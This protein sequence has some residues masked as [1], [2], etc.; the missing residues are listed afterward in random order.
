M[1]NN[2]V[3][4]TCSKSKYNRYNVPA[5]MLYKGPY[6]QLKLKYAMSLHLPIFIISAL[7]GLIPMEK[8][9]SVYDKTIDLLTERERETI[10]DQIEKF[11][12]ICKYG[13]IYFIGSGRYL[14][15]F[16]KIKGRIKIESPI[17]GLDRID[18]TKYLRERIKEL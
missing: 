6:F 7:Y 8:E 1:S 14:F 15:L 18:G 4:I 5:Y 13:K 17:A 9:I 12:S 2:I 3:I 11:F 16:D 10:Q